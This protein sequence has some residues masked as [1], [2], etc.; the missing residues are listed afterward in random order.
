MFSNYITLRRH[1]RRDECGS[2]RIASRQGDLTN[3]HAAESEQLA[4]G[5]RVCLWGRFRYTRYVPTWGVHAPCFREGPLSMSASRDYDLLRKA[6]RKKRE[7]NSHGKRWNTVDAPEPAV[8]I[9]KTWLKCRIET[10]N[11]SWSMWVTRF[12]SDRKPFQEN[13]IQENGTRLLYAINVDVC[14]WIHS[15][16]LA[17]CCQPDVADDT[18]SK[19]FFRVGQHQRR[20]I[21]RDKNV[22]E[23]YSKWDND[24]YLKN[25]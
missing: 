12:V 20:C 14:S 25:I 9:L 10:W 18:L 21:C 11:I 19:L 13:V 8:V 22:I 15:L 17:T 1:V 16:P 6:A 3:F 4:I 5:A 7:A 24:S 23:G 2:E